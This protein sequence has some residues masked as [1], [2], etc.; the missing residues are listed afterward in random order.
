MH[1]RSG[2]LLQGLSPRVRGNRPA[3]CPFT[4]Y[5]GSI[6]ACAGEPH[7]I[8]RRLPEIPVYPRVCGGTITIRSGS[9]QRYG[10]SPRVRGNPFYVSRRL[11]VERSIPACA[12]EPGPKSGV[13]G[14]WTVYPRVCGGTFNTGAG[15]NLIPG[16]SPRVRGNQAQYVPPQREIRSIPACAGEP[17]S[18]F[19]K[20]PMSRVYPRVCGGTRTLN[21]H[22]RYEEGLSPRVR[23]NR[24]MSIRPRGP[25]RSIPACAGEPASWSGLSSID[26][27]YPRVCGGTSFNGTGPYRQ[28]GLS[29]RVRGNRVP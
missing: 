15:Q 26:R 11:L 22:L 7:P 1:H 24:Q 27:V 4:S 21:N 29:P 19:P 6:P 17:S 8:T 18:S 5:A 23:G 9:S 12:G 28:R 2:V 14:A 10:L 13:T 3:I 25:T 16:L 20:P